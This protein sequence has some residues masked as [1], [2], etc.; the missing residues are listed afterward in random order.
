MKEENSLAIEAKQNIEI[1]CTTLCDKDT[2]IQYIKQLEEDNEKLK[3]QI[4]ELRR[5]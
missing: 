1:C 4:A 3:R 5:S 2:V